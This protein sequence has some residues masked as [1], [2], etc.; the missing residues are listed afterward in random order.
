MHLSQVWC[1][2]H[3]TTARCSLRYGIERCQREDLH[4]PLVLVYHTRCGHYVR[5]GLENVNDDLALEVSRPNIHRLYNY[6][7]N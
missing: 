2:R 6:S 7:K 1:F 3:D 5:F 4:R